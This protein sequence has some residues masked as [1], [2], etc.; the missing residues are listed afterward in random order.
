VIVI[1]WLLGYC[2]EAERQERSSKVFQAV[3]LKTNTFFNPTA[4]P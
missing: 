2:V 4:L 3:V 1:V